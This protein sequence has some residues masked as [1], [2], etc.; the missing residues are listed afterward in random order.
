MDSI[1]IAARG[2]A[3]YIVFCD[4][5][6]G[7][8][9]DFVRYAVKRA[10]ETLRSENFRGEFG[11]HA[12]N[13]RGLAVANSLA[14]VEEGVNLVEGTINGIGERCG[15]TDLLTIIGNLWEDGKIAADVSGLTHLSRVVEEVTGVPVSKG[16]PYVGK[17]AFTTKAGDHAKM[18]AKKRRFYEH[19][20]PSA[21][22]NRPWLS[23][24]DQAG[25][26][27]VTE[28]L[29][30]DGYRVPEKT[31]RMIL[32]AVKERAAQGYHYEIAHPSFEM[33]ARRTAGEKVDLFTSSGLRITTKVNP[34]GESESNASIFLR[35]EDF[36]RVQT[37]DRGLEEKIEGSERFLLQEEDRG[38]KLK[39]EVSASG[40]V[41]AAYLALYKAL[42]PYFPEISNIHLTDYTVRVV[43]SKNGKEE[44]GTETVVRVTGTFKD[45][46]HKGAHHWTTVGVHKDQGLAALQMLMEGINYKLFKE[47]YRVAG[48]TPVFEPISNTPK[49]T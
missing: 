26:E 37:N 48:Y 5:N 42:S 22:G 18:L 30:R 23:I 19:I 45:G 41:D 17:A 7:S 40:A 21:V 10:I 36:Y 1:R 20:D 16:H 44:A 35:L 14:A 31:E 3:D 38:V 2:G 6:G 43:T 13:D 32:A 29:K 34:R 47:G 49:P 46:D 4:T 33:L 25:V 24:S 28:L 12:H 11:I 8:N 15:N 27:V 39:E 9:T